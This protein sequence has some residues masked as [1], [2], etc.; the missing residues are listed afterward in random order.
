MQFTVRKCQYLTG[1]PKK[2]PEEKKMLFF[3]FMNYRQC[4][5]SAEFNR[6]RNMKQNIYEILTSPKTK[7]N[8]VILNNCID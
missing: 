6:S 8:D 2:N 4:H 7:T 1:V 3:L 5:M